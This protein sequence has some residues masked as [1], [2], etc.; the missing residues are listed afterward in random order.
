MREWVVRVAGRTRGPSP[1]GYALVEQ[2][3]CV[4]DVSGT[5]KA[6]VGISLDGD[7]VPIRLSN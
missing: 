7:E 4:P 1:A 5:R 3:A 2:A 6:K